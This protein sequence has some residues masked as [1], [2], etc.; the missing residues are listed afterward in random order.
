[1]YAKVFDVYDDI[2]SFYLV[3]RLHGMS[4]VK[5]KIDCSKLT[6]LE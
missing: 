1:M 4:L 5:I 2:G 6:G 3:N